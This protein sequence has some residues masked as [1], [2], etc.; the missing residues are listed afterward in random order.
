VSAIK[1][2]FNTSGR[3]S[4]IQKTLAKNPSFFGLWRGFS[5]LGGTALLQS[6][7]N[8]KNRG[9]RMAVFCINTEKR[10]YYSSIF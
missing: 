5:S 2:F 1:R 4:R 7:D 10:A 8:P 9:H 6:W 3:Y